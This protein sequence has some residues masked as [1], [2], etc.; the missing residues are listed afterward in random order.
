MPIRSSNDNRLKAAVSVSEMARMCELSRS[1]FN[2][3]IR[4][5]VMPQPIYSLANRR[6]FYDAEHQQIC[7]RVRETNIGADG[8]YVVFYDRRR[9]SPPP[10]SAPAR[11]SR[12]AAPPPAEAHAELVEG[13]R[14]LGLTDTTAAQVDDAIRAC[15]PSGHDGIDEGTVLRELWRHLRRMNGE[16]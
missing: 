15:Y 3:L 6:P 11:T 1:H 16:R 14:A 4:T 2:L 10:S 12:R 8:K 5:G 9:V 13:L 7:L